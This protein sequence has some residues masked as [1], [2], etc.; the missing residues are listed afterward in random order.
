MRGSIRKRE[1]KRGITWQA[2]VDLPPNPATGKRRQKM[3]TADTKKE[4]E[5]MAAQ[6]IASIEGGGFSEAD[7]KKITV[8]EYMTRWLESI[9]QS[10][11]PA[12]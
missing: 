12:S 1:G 6:Y 9:S 11:R 7:A 8:S 2:R 10:K 4:V 5:A 3:L